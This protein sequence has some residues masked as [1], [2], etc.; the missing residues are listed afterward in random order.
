MDGALCEWEIFAPIRSE[1]RRRMRA[2]PED[3]GIVPALRN[4]YPC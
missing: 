3:L 1:V 2:S 4:R